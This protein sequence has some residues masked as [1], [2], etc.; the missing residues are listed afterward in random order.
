[1]LTFGSLTRVLSE[2][3]QRSLGG[4]REWGVVAEQRMGP[5]VRRTRDQ[6]LLVRCGVRYAPRRS[7]AL[8][9]AI[10]RL[11]A[12]ALRARFPSLPIELEHTWGG[13]LGMTLNGATQ[14]GPLGGGIWSAAGYN[15]VG[16]A[17][18][19]TLGSLLADLIVGADSPALADARAMPAPSWIPPDPFLGIG[20][21][22]TLAAMRARAGDEAC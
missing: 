10:E 6:R 12:D 13:V 7:E 15:G 2:A 22:A 1:M 17:L 9:A 14:F 4:Q 18:G 5:T 11:H 19:T 20:V 16:V 21:R 8:H 3:E